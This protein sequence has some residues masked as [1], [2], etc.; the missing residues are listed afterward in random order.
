MMMGLRDRARAAALTGIALYGTPSPITKHKRYRP[1]W[2]TVLLVQVMS[3]ATG[4][5]PFRIYRG[6]R[7]AHNS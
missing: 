6:L 4:A 5:S 2:R 3:W 1:G 7:N